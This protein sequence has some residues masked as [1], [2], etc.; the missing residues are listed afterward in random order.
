MSNLAL[1]RLLL[2]AGF[3]AVA[4][5]A[6]VASAQKPDA[7]TFP[8]RPIRVIV[9]SS[10]GGPVD[11]TARAVGQ[12]FTER[13]GQQIVLDHRAGAGG[14][15]GHELAV[16]AAPDG[17][18]LIF[19]TAAGL[20]VNPLLSKLSYDPLRDLTPISLG[21]IN[22]QLLFTHPA[23]PATNMQELIALAKAKP[24]QLNCA[25]AGNGTPN[26]LGCELLKTMAGI[27]VVHVP[28][29]GSSPAI[30]DVVG[31]QIQFML[32]SIP[33]VLPLAKAGKIRVLGVSTA[34]RTPA[35]PEIP[36]IAQTLPGF[37]YVNWF[38]LMAPAGTPAPIINKINAEVVR[39]MADPAFAQRL[40]NQGAEP[41]ASTPFHVCTLKP[42]KPASAKVGVSG[43]EPTLWSPVTPI[44][45][46]LPLLT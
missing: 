22:P 8:T 43:K 6:P 41:R 36:P 27:E 1:P 30:V 15:I 23:V 32:N 35:A 42:G 33:S 17:Y 12:R 24:N 46:S 31:G 34:E 38:A 9:P 2:L 45:R 11:L 7:Q 10:P 40:I 16:K 44:A 28:Y 20:V 19:S 25:S 37:E 21:S 4:L 5:L 26:H 13:W 14:I 29:K 39:M 3:T 18:T